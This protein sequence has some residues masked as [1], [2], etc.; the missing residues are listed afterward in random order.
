VGHRIAS[1]NSWGP[2]PPLTR[3]LLA[4]VILVG[5]AVI[6]C[7]SEPGHGETTD[8]A[9]EALS[10]GGTAGTSCKST[11]LAIVD[12]HG[13]PREIWQGLEQPDTGKQADPNLSVTLDF[14]ASVQAS[15][16]VTSFVPVAQDG[17]CGGAI[18]ATSSLAVVPADVW[19]QLTTDTTRPAVPS[20]FNVFARDQITGLVNAGGPIAA[21]KDVTLSSLSV[22]GTVREPVGLIAGGKVTLTSGSVAGNVTYGVASTFPQTVTVSGTKSLLPFDP[23]AE[24]LKLEALST[25]LDEIPTTG[26]ATLTN[27]TLKL[28][29][30]KSGLNVFRVTAE[31]LVQATSV[32]LSAPAGAAVLID[33]S[34]TT[35]DFEN[36]GISLSGV[37]ASGLLWNFPAASSLIVSAV[38]L[39]GSL[40]APRARFQF[41]SGSINGTV[42]AQSF[43]GAGSGSLQH[44]PL[45]VSLV[46]GS[47]APAAVTLTPAQ[48]LKRG[49]T[50]RLALPATQALNSA[51]A[52][53]GTP[54]SVTFKVADQT[55]AP[56]GRE[57]A[58]VE[59]DLKTGMFRRFT[60]KSGI[61]TPIGEVWSRYE[62]APGISATELVPAGKPL[63]SS[64]AATQTVQTYQQYAQGYPVA[65]FGYSVTS[66]NG[67]FRNA[68]GRVMPNLP[69]LPQPSVTAATA[70]QNVLARLQVNPAPWVAK[71]A[72]YK[73]PV[74]TLALVP[75][76][77]VPSAQEFALAWIFEFDATNGIGNARF[78]AVDAVTGAILRSS[79]GQRRAPLNS[80]AAYVGPVLTTV[81]TDYNGTLPLTVAQYRN[82]DTSLVTTLA[83]GDVYKPG[84]LAVLTG[85]YPDTTTSG[86]P[87]IGTPVYLTDPTPATPWTH[88]EELE[89][90]L[91]AAQWAL[92]QSNQT[93]KSANA[94]LNGT[95]WTSIDG[96]GTQRVN[97]IYTDPTHTA[98]DTAYYSPTY[99]KPSDT[100]I[101]FP[102][103]RLHHGPD[104][105]PHEY[106]HA[107]MDSVRR[108]IGS[109]SVMDFAESGSVEEGLADLFM[110]LFNHDNIQDFPWWCDLYGNIALDCLENMQDPSQ[111]TFDG[112][113]PTSLLDPLY[114]PFTSDQ[115]CVDGN[116]PAQN[117]RPAGNDRC[118]IHHNSTIV[119]HWA[120]LLA[121]GTQGLADVPCGLTL[122]PIAADPAVGLKLAFNL[123]LNAQRRMGA[124][125]IDFYASFADLRD[126]TLQTA[127]ELALAG[128]I[129][130][131]D[132]EKVALAWAAMGLPPQSTGSSSA[133]VSP[134][135]GAQNVYP[136]TQFEWPVN[137]LGQT[138]TSWDFQL[139][140]AASF[141]PGHVLYTATDITTVVDDF[142]GQHGALPLTLPYDATGTFYWRVRPHASDTT[143]PGCYPIHS[144]AGTSHPKP[145]KNLKVLQSFD[146]QGK[147]VPGRVDFVWDIVAGVKAYVVDAATT[148]R[149]CQSGDGVIES[150][151]DHPDPFTYY[152]V[153]GFA[154]AEHYFVGVH[155][156]GPPGFDGKPAVGDC[157]TIEL[158]TG[159]PE[160]PFFQSPRDGEA[161]DDQLPVPFKYIASQGTDHLE[162]RFSELDET[163][164][165]SPP[166]NPVVTVPKS[167]PPACDDG[168][169]QPFPTPNLTGYCWQANG[170]TKSGQPTAATPVQ[171]FHFYHDQ[172]MKLSPGV[173]R[174]N[175]E[176]SSV[177]GIPTLPVT[178][179]TLAGDSYGQDVPL[180]WA[181]D[182]A[183]LAFGYRL[184]AWGQNDEPFPVLE[185]EPP[186]CTLSGAFSGTST[187]TCS[188]PFDVRASGTSTGASVLVTDGLASQGRYCWNV[189][190]LFGD[191]TNPTQ[192][193][194]RQPNVVLDREICYTSGPSHPVIVVDNPPGDI[195]S[196]SPITGHVEL[197]YVPDG[198]YAIA[199][200]AA[201]TAEVLGAPEFVTGDDCTRDSYVYQDVH[202]CRI[203]FTITPKPGRKYLVIA[204]TW[205]SDQHPPVLD[206]STQITPDVTKEIDVA[207][208]GNI[209]EPCCHESGVLHCT[210][211]KSTCNARTDK[212]E[213]CGESGELC[214]ND[215]DHGGA[216]YCPAS[217]GSRLGCDFFGDLR[218]KKCG[219]SGQPCCYS[220]SSGQYSC[221]SG[222]CSEVLKCETCGT[223]GTHCCLGQNG[224]ALCNAN[225]TCTPNSTGQHDC[226]PNCGIE[227]LQCCP[228]STCDAG[229]DCTGGA[230]AKPACQVPATPVLSGLND[231]QR[232]CTPNGATTQL[233]LDLTLPLCDI[234]PVGIQQLVNTQVIPCSSGLAF[235]WPAVTGA[236]RYEVYLYDYVTGSSARLPDA[237][238]PSVNVPTCTVNQTAGC[239]P[240][241]GGVYDPTL[242]TIVVRA[243]NQ[244][245]QKSGAGVGML[246]LKLTCGG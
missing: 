124:T 33:A 153:A 165:C 139:A 53:L 184:W 144:F 208:C 128:T 101:V 73:A 100:Y 88:P 75:K 42:V 222:Q 69:S 210:Q 105:V 34:G 220:T 122:D 57:L 31:Q 119:S 191:P 133:E 116:E 70:L 237:P 77:F 187:S 110:L 138:A 92:E 86:A 121:S 246:A 40:L 87:L 52:C 41:G 177:D 12:L 235:I 200:V 233:D 108:T 48:A 98:Y 152:E 131:G 230:C 126:Y 169:Q 7:A 239:I 9:S 175:F 58:N 83:N 156:L 3:S 229:L 18:A 123:A 8:R 27:G 111:S 49:C 96:A 28:A 181:P 142:G 166:S 193:G 60:A 172:T 22:N 91:A 6:G 145:L 216:L 1:G 204:R 63:K 64:T 127:Q 59:V 163:D 109:G 214:C 118:G 242:L 159:I 198:Q 115:E 79:S 90:E 137:G 26:S 158:D 238:Q 221:T 39:Q 55:S 217:D 16:L 148:D 174:A 30:T 51:G 197:T 140:D 117:G 167:C 243:V 78:M 14:N 135:D 192:V 150:T 164:H 107:L 23:N 94:V 25:L 236:L 45:T 196:P 189:W 21:G 223:R 66:E 65:G 129:S 212:C 194:P 162:L 67:I 114:F 186:N 209:G 143:W 120:Y 224:T 206:E 147:V 112:G 80:L 155:A 234:G 141:A 99:Y 146:A 35:V 195:Y 180:E 125:P 56:A 185:V 85:I 134:V 178:N 203:D 46:L 151:F 240:I 71:P 19:G 68:V 130:S 11:T 76:K 84:T 50:Y 226:L 54:F 93:L 179:S 89:R 245:G 202:D 43:V 5:A 72:T 74:G 183:A 171:K 81:D 173:D 136:W 38:G 47:S 95:P 29:G 227:G 213:E 207:A 244:C 188:L 62:S 215:P 170:V 61:N 219:G 149:H 17:S 13:D 199:A 103:S 157:T 231:Y 102:D 241:P 154:G 225:L 97:V 104:L 132:A 44:T 190:P 24:F 4:I 201:D 82:P 168:F 2:S 161:F 211:A 15:S 37:A 113:Q 205:N 182:P 32:Q 10:S 218:C 176:G 232:F 36:K 228:G 160:A 20:P 106:G